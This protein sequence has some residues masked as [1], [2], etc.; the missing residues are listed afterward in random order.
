[1]I[2]L[3]ILERKVVRCKMDHCKPATIKVGISSFMISGV[4]F[5]VPCVPRL[6]IRFKYQVMRR[7]IGIYSISS[8]TCFSLKNKTRV[9]KQAVKSL[10]Q[11][12]RRFRNT[13]CSTCA[14][15]SGTNMF[16]YFKTDPFSCFERNRATLITDTDCATMRRRQCGTTMGATKR[17]AMLKRKFTPLKCFT[18]AFTSLRRLHTSRTNF[19]STNMAPRMVFSAAL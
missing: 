12:C 14:A 10:L 16:F 8:Y 2:C 9:I 1:M 11:F 15:L 18:N 17:L 7:N 19:R 13:V 5:F 3:V 6:S 4:S